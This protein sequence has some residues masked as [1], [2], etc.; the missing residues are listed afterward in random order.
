[1]PATATSTEIPAKTA[2]VGKSYQRTNSDYLYFNQ[3][4]NESNEEK[5]AEIPKEFNM[6]DAP[7]MRG[8][9]GGQFD[10]HEEEETSFP[11][12]NLPVKVGKGRG[13][14]SL[15]PV[16]HDSEMRTTDEN[17]RTPPTASNQS[18][19][20]NSPRSANTSPSGLVVD[21]DICDYEKKTR[22]VE[23]R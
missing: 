20:M 8:I 17:T 12:T 3:K 21:V 22:V 5:I 14:N 16:T 4:E 6:D 23:R 19:T 10:F 13:M 9:T 1:M 18:S 2:V 15:F 7:Y 11:K